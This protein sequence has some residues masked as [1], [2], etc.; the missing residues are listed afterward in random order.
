MLY[1][2]AI[3]FI[4]SLIAIYWLIVKN[5]SKVKKASQDYRFVSTQKKQTQRDM[6]S[7]I[8]A[9]IFSALFTSLILIVVINE[10][11]S[12]TKDVATEEDKSAPLEETVEEPELIIEEPIV[13]SEKAVTTTKKPMLTPEQSAEF[14][15]GQAALM[16]YVYEN[17]NYF[18]RDIDNGNQGT[19]YVKFVINKDGSVSDVKVLKGINKRLDQE[20]IRVVESLPKWKPGTNEGRPVRMYFNLPIRLKIKG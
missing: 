11:P 14:P 2:I 6:G 1:L 7:Y 5:K 12:F 19:I 9:I 3:V 10:F 4:I 13:P 17:F 18:Q 16:K 20:A 15:G 8:Y